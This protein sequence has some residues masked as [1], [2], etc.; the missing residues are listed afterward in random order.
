MNSGQSLQQV[1]TDR[2]WVVSM[3]LKQ[4][5]IRVEAVGSDQV[6]SRIGS[7]FEKVW[8]QK[9]LSPLGVEAKSAGGWRSRIAIR[10]L[11]AKWWE[12]EVD[13]DNALKLVVIE[14]DDGGVD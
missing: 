3:D 7:G 10:F 1:R 11:M 6:D 5:Q 13:G 9:L 4:S 12:K 2:A 14:G 8:T